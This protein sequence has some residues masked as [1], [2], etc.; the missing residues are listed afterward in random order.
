MNKF[1]W[2]E[3]PPPQ[4]EAVATLARSLDIPEAGA[5]FLI[6]RSLTDADEVRTLS[7]VLDDTA[8]SNAERDD[9]GIF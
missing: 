5:R 7:V 4:R 9:K 8:L 2:Q 6:S 3:T 1:Q